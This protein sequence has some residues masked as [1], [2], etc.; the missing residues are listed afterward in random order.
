VKARKR[1]YFLTQSKRSKVGIDKLVPFYS[2][3][4][5]PSLEYA[6]PVFHK[7]LSNY[8]SDDLEMIQK[9]AFRII[10]PW[11][12]YTDALTL[13]GLQNLS[14]IREKITNKLFEDITMDENH[15]LYD[16]F[17]PPRNTCDTDL[18]SKHNFNTN[19][20]TDRFKNSFFYC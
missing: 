14:T 6:C 1:L 4:I 9:R 17:L 2:T 3:C 20:R 11:T 8:L 15:K 13:T 12:P 7:S 19:F 18:R 5:R 10:Y 16:E